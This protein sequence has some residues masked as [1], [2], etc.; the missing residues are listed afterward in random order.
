MLT[1]GR[2]GVDVQDEM[3]LQ[4]VTEV[5]WSAQVSELLPQPVLL[6]LVCYAAF[7]LSP[8]LPT[9]LRMS[10]TFQGFSKPVYHKA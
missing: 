8:P 4:V 3:L 7:S 6:G 1:W 10:S 2:V 9:P 5:G